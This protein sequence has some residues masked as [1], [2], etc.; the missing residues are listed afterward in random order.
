MCSVEAITNEP[1]PQS[2]INKSKSGA[3]NIIRWATRWSY[4]WVR[5][6]MRT[7]SVIEVFYLK[8]VPSN[9][10]ANENFPDE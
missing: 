1:P 3:N 5:L 9:Y 7:C 4:F 10:P 2:L 8:N 6:R